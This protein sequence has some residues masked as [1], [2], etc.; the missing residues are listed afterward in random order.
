M[1]I[2]SSEIVWRRGVQV[3]LDNH[4]SRKH[5]WRFDGGVEVDASSS[6]Q[7]VPLP[8]SE[9]KAVDP[10]EVFVASLSSCHMLWFL[11]IAAKR[12]FVVDEYQDQASGVMQKND[13]G[14]LAMTEVVLR[15]KVQFSGNRLP[16]AAQIHLMHE[17]AHEECFIAHSVKTKVRCEP[18]LT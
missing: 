7:V 12:G 14:K 17:H 1:A 15:P 10:E 9:E 8:Y 6:P 18:L 11:S 3:F 5:V 13:A 2:Y 16:D 4:Y